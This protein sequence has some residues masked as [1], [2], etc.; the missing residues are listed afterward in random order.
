MDDWARAYAEE[1]WRRVE[2]REAHLRDLAAVQERAEAAKQRV[3]A[4]EAALTSL[5]RCVRER[6]PRAS[7]R[8]WT[9]AAAPPAAPSKG[10]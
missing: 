4:L 7:Y 8:V 5:W 2:D 9:D 10:A 1:A 3:A 6:H